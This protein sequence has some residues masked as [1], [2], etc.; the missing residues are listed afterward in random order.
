MATKASPLTTTKDPGKDALK[1]D[2]AE[3]AEKAEKA[4]DT[5]PASATVPT[6]NAKANNN[7]NILLIVGGILLLC[8]CCV[9]LCGGAFFAFGVLDADSDSND[10]LEELE[11]S[12][13][14]NDGDA[15]PVSGAET[16]RSKE[17]G[18]WDVTLDEVEVDGDTYILTISATNT[19]DVADS[20]SAL[21]QLSLVD[22]ND[23][24][25]FRDYL[26]EIDASDNL[27]G[28][29][30]AG[31]TIEGKIAFTVNSDPDELTLEVTDSILS[32][33]KVTFRIK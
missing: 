16:G 30:D 12:R 31:E 25:Y 29:V 28:Y 22:D 23:R 7:T 20:F 8:C 18:N 2:K 27:G 19:D 11:R 3:K 26:Y 10:F 24:E 9:V 21:G 1:V 4:T 32:T 17:V 33:D 6:A 15:E 5:K 14:D 13:D